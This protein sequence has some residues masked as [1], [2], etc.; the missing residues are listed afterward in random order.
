M[1]KV[2]WRWM[3]SGDFIKLER[4][5]KTSCCDCGLAHTW[6]FRKRKGIYGFIVTR[7]NRATGQLRRHMDR[8]K[9]K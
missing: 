4:T 6:E 9:D 2:A 8:K 7:D 1:K 3:S 5:F